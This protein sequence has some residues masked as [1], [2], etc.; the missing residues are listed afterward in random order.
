MAVVPGTME[1]SDPEWKLKK[2][3]VEEQRLREMSI[4]KKDKQL[5][6]KIMFSKKRKAKEVMLIICIL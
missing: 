6:N 3:D 4:P 1:R 5:Y 2:Q